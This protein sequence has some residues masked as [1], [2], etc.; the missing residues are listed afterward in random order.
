MAGYPDYTPPNDAADPAVIEAAVEDYL[1][2]NPPGTPDHNDTTLRDAAAAH[3]ATSITVDA[4]GFNGNLAATDDTVQEIAQKLDDLAIPDL[5]GHLSDA[6]DAHDA[7]AI[8]IGTLNGNLSAVTGTDVE[9]ALQAVDNL[10]LGGSVATDAIWDA[11][12]DLAYGTGANTASRLALGT[13]GLALISGTSAPE[14]DVRMTTGVGYVSTTVSNCIAETLGP[15]TGIV[16][17]T[18]LT[19]GR[20]T[21]VGIH[22]PKHTT[23][24]SISFASGGTG[25]ATGTNQWFVLCDNTRTSLRYTVNDTSTAWG[26]STLKTL[27]LTSTF[28]TTYSGLYYVGVMVAATTVPSLRGLA[29]G[30]TSPVLIECFHSDTGLTTVPGTTTFTRGAQSALQAWAAVS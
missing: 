6:T 5:A 30:T 8:S 22:L 15:D 4:T 19:S 10:S 21:L 29:Q 23:I 16:N 13:A 3:P 17:G 26:T 18:P 9:Q 11:A 25:L 27:A 28:T 7:S 12:G 24:T 1:I 20:L 2:A 14:Y